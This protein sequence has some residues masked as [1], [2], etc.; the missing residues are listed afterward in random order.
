[1]IENYDEKDISKSYTN[2]NHKVK[3]G[4]VKST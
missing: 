2:I 3:N 4:L 1:M